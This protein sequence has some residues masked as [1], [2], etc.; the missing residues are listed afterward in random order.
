[1]EEL[2]MHITKGRKSNG[3]GY[4]LY[5]SKSTTFWKHR[6]I[7]RDRGKIGSPQGLIRGKDE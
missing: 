3:K 6:T 5:H 2:S 7:Y 4:K 1:M